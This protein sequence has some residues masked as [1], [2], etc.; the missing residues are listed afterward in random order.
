MLK[1][2]LTLG[3]GLTVWF[4]QAQEK[5]PDFYSKELSFTTDNDAYLLQN[6]DAYYTNGFFIRL[7]NTGQKKGNKKPR[8]YELGQMMY[9]VCP[10]HPKPKRYRQTLLRVPF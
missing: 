2:L 4:G 3:T 6:R 10:Q 5:R 7:T 9:P 1:F 8:K